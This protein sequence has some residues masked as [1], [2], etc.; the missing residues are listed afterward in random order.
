MGSKIGRQTPTYT[1]VPEKG[2]KTKGAEAIKLYKGTGQKL[3]KWQELQISG[4]MS[5]DPSGL[6]KYVKYCVCVSRRN[7]K[8]EILAAR[9]LWGIVEAGEKICHTAHRVS[10]SHAAWERLRKLLTDAGYVELGRKVKITPTANGKG[11]IT[12][13]FY[14][15]KELADLAKKIVD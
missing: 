15:D 8:G 13:E 6:W 5:M 3:F 12:L 9:E 10:T 11:T 4:I 2:L 14:S 1:N 7:G